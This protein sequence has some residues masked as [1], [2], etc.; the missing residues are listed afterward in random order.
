MSAEAELQR[1]NDRLELLLNLTTRITSDLDLRE[2][3][4][5]I[6]ANIRRA[7]LLTRYKSLEAPLTELRKTS[8]EERSHADVREPE[9]LAGE[10]TNSLTDNSGIAGDYA[11]K[12]RHEIVRAL[13]ASKGRVGGAQMVLLHA[14]A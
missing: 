9:Q 5:A 13:T 7:V 4:R 14:W 8:A 11:R 1:Q 10:R 12:R 6:A 2:V 3:L